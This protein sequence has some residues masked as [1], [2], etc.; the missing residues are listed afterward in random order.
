VLSRLLAFLLIAESLFHARYVAGL[1]PVLAGYDVVA[2]VLIVARGLIAALQFMGGWTLATS[3]PAARPLASTALIAA[4]AL[5]TLDVG[6]DLA[7]TSVY[8]WLRWQVTGG[9]W[10]YAL[11]AA[12]YLRVP[13]P[14]Q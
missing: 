11:A 1:L 14:R 8:H 9:Y 7:P 5:T 12:W 2:V 13:T 3:R 4:A 10:A 6:L